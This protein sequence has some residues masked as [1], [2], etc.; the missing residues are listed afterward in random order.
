M[1]NTGFLILFILADL[2]LLTLMVVWMVRYH[3]K[4]ERSRTNREF[5]NF[6]L[7]NGI[8]FDNKQLLNKNMIGIDRTAMTLVFLDRSKRSNQVFSISLQ[9][10]EKS[11]FVKEKSKNT[12]NIQRIFLRIHFKD[13]R[14]AI[15][16]PIYD[17][18]RDKFYK[19]MRLAK[20]GLYWN[21]TINL[22][23]ELPE[24]IEEE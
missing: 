14:E 3:N 10:I 8:R 5:E 24:E 9:D 2:I 17:E 1:N 6:A 4:K 12:G 19:M 15:V 7:L 13:G 11:T 21:K 18:N 23:K 16:F 22:F 20:K